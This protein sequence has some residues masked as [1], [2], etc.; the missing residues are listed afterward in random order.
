MATRDA[1]FDN[2]KMALVLLV[3][4]GHAWTL[5]PFNADENMNDDLRNLVWRGHYL[6]FGPA[7]VQVTVNGV[8]TTVKADRARLASR[9]AKK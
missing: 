1:W 8:T 3:V 2:A 4:V 9:G 7:D 5:L 6:G